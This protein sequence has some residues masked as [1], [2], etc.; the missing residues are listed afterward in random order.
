MREEQLDRAFA[1]FLLSSK[2]FRDR[3][4][5]KT[6]FSGVAQEAVLLQQEQVRARPR[7]KPENWWKHWWCRLDDGSESE[8]DIFGVLGLS[9]SGTRVALL[10]ENKTVHGK[11]TPAQPESYARRAKF[12]A[13]KPKYLNYS[14][15]VCLLI[16]PNRFLS[17]NEDALS[18][19]DSV[20]PYES[21]GKFVPEFSLAL[22]R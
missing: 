6:R 9:R 7:T 1:N 12:I 14:E 2:S 4:L 10:I 15:Y 20:L 3:I 19:F 5:H 8:T 21:I 18:H 22:E 17:A 16:A 13:N 11:F